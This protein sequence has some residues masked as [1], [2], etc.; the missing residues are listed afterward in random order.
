MQQNR[1]HVRGALAQSL[2]FVLVIIGE[3]VVDM[4]GTQQKVGHAL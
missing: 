3:Q 2:T 1:A 4:F